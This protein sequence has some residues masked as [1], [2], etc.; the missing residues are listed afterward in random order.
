MKLKPY[1]EYKD[2][3][4]EWIGEIPKTWNIE[5]LK[6][7]VFIIDGD[8][9]N[10]YPN[11]NDLVDI[12]IPFLSTDCLVKNQI[13]F[14]KSKFITKNKFEKLRGGK[15]KPG[16]L[17]I[18]VRGTIGNTALFLNNKFDTGFINA[19]MMILRPY[20]IIPQILN[21]ISLSPL[22]KNQLDFNAYGSAQKQLSNQILSNFLLLIPSKDE[23]TSMIDFLD[24]KT[25]EIDKT[26]Q[27]DTRLIELLKEKRTALINHVVTKGFDP[28]AKLKDSGIEWIGEIPE[29]WEI[30]KAKF[31]ANIV[32]GAILR[33]VDEPSYFDENGIYTYLN[34]SDVTKSQ[35]YLTNGKLK[36]SE[37]GSTKSLRI[38]P[39]NLLL[40]AS[41]TIGIPIINKIKVCI[42]D[43]FIA[44]KNLRIFNEYLYYLL[45]NK[46][47][48]G[49]LGK[50]NTQKN[51]YLDEVKNI[52]L[53]IP[54]YD[55][56]IKIVD[57]LDIK[58]SKIDNTIQKIQ[59]KI[60]LMEE[61]KKSLI[62]HV[63]TGKV[64]VREVAV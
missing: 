48:Y 21:Y 12:G 56:Q 14:S 42:H 32:R 19:Q 27:K 35:K 61:Y 7:N 29:G 64:D 3:M 18:S 52:F 11:E 54:K 39:N 25:S 22:W 6:H 13:D 33:P 41:A 51:I 40:T 47:I 9:G 57:Y 49:E 26:I 37:L 62:H 34:I 20:K 10:E 59:N 38:E 31:I 36:L 8:R 44:F 45:Q 16:D 55:E 30:K 5:K 46:A 17:I 28:N 43:G 4:V 24:K 1:P 23:Q 63:V 2:S 60:Y 58:T 50:S 53:S 15:L